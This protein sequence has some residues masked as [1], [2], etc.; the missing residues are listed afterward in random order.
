MGSDG[1]REAGKTSLL[2][3][4]AT[5]LFGDRGTAIRFD[6]ALAVDIDSHRGSRVPGDTGAPGRSGSPSVANL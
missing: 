6:T 2:S 3:Y 4:V 1:G 5:T